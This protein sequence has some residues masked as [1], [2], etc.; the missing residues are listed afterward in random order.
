MS[1]WRLPRGH[2]MRI[3]K[4]VILVPSDHVKDPETGQ[5][6]VKIRCKHRS[7]RDLRGLVQRVAAEI[8]DQESG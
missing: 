8:E 4:A 6:C 3:Y 5:A 1:D 7:I 2:K